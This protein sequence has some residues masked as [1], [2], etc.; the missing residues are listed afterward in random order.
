MGC[1]DTGSD[2]CPCFLADSGQCIACPILRGAD[3]CDACSWNG[4]CV[5]DAYVRGEKGGVR[6][7]VRT[8]IIRRTTIGDGLHMVTLDTPETWQADLRLP[9]S[10]VMVKPPG[11]EI[12]WSC[13]MAV[14]YVQ[15]D[16]KCR[17]VYGDRGP[18]T[19]QLSRCSEI[20]EISGPY[21]SGLLGTRR[22][23]QADCRSVLLLVSGTGQSLLPNILRV[24]RSKGCTGEL[25]LD[26]GIGGVT[27]AMDHLPCFPGEVFLQNLDDDG[28]ECRPGWSA[29]TA[30]I[31]GAPGHLLISLGSDFLHRRVGAAR[32]TNQSW[33][34]SNNQIMVCGSGWCGACTVQLRD[35]SEARGCKADVAPEDVI[36]R[37]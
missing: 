29:V 2:A 7:F 31:A 3:S 19:N 36:W 5:Y 34:A 30:R 32:L 17:I 16:G 1:H 14:F 4:A 25:L 35:G 6:R 22:L 37:G 13:P 9:G 21:R 33:V 12:T 20:W 11:A 23:L 27:Y 24:L 10:F 26:P 28:E 15:P 8:R 18:K